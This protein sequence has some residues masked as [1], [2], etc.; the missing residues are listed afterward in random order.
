MAQKIKDIIQEILEAKAQT[1]ELSNL[2]VLTQ[3]EINT[4]ENLST[5]KVA[6]WRIWVYVVAVGIWSL[7]K[8]FDLFK[9]EIEQRI[10][11]SRPHTKAW[12]RNLALNF[13][14]GYQLQETAIYDLTGL[15]DE[16]I[17]AAKI[18]KHAAVV[19][20]TQ[21]GYGVL[22]IKVATE[23]NLV[24]EPITPIQ[25]AAFSNYMNKVTDAGTLI[26]PTTAIPD[27]LKLEIDLYYNP[28]IMSNT[29]VFLDGSSDAPVVESI[30]DFLRSIDFNG[31]FVKTY[32]EDHL[33]GVK[34]VEIPVIKKA[35]SKYGGHSYD[36]T[37]IQNAGVIDELRIADAGYMKLDINNTIINYIPRV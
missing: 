28:E 7:E 33:K 12:Y 25:M 1:A 15:T 2:E 21:S 5:S 24:R 37:T 19:K 14:F 22:R 23:N 30:E 20:K 9:I 26:E 6:E 17:Q 16:Q 36:D 8:L 4:L 35:W 13:H 18:I 29:G 3:N 32:L 10:A 34:G 27:D 11:E 31:E